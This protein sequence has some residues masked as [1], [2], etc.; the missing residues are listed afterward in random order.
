MNG[1]LMLLETLLSSE[2]EKTL[3]ILGAAVKASKRI[4]DVTNKLTNIKK[5][6][7]SKYGNGVEMLNL[8]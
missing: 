5:I 2:D 8:E 1:N 3:K 6:E 7:F 4:E